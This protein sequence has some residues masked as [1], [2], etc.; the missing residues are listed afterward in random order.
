MKLNIFL[1]YFGHHTILIFMLEEVR[2]YLFTFFIF[3]CIKW[4]LWFFNVLIL[5]ERIPANTMPDKSGSM[6]WTKFMEITSN[7]LFFFPVWAQIFWW[8][9]RNI[10]WV[11]FLKTGNL[12][13]SEVGGNLIISNQQKHIWRK[14]GQKVTLQSKSEQFLIDWVQQKWFGNTQSY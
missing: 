11:S 4:Y 6:K 12:A 14:P 1:I 10:F 13:S 3:S 9:Q 7:T 5:C 2:L 8:T